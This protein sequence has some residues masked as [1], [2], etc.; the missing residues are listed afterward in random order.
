MMLWQLSAW[1]GCGRREHAMGMWGRVGVAPVGSVGIGDGADAASRPLIRKGFMLA[2]VLLAGSSASALADDG[3]VTFGPFGPWSAPVNLGPPIN[4]EYEESAPAQ[5]DGG[6]I[7]FNRNFNGRNPTF[8]EKRDEDLY[9]THRVLGGTWSAPVALDALNTPTF[10]ERNAAFSPDARLLFFSSDRTGG[11]GGLDL[12][13]SWRTDRHDDG[14]W[15]VPLNLGPT[16]NSVGGEVG[17]AYVEDEAG[18]TVLYFTVNRGQGADIFRTEVIEPAGLRRDE[19]GDGKVDPGVV[20]PLMPVSELNSPA[21]DA[22]P[23]I[24]LDGLEV[25]F[26]SNRTLVQSACADPNNPPSGGQDLWFSTR[27]SPTDPWSCPTNL[28]SDVNTAV[29]D[30]QAH[31]ADDAETL[32]YSGNGPDGSIMDDIWLIRRARLSEED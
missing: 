23:A 26:H 14:A 8:P 10:N 15:S 22:R 4:T 12:Y 16:V 13:V 27:S 3:D 9:V 18:I 5:S 30:I 28:G 24:R 19:N 21:G 2:L 29:N 1:V 6:T 32:Y 31:L 17:P 11:S 7:Y 20:G 25:F